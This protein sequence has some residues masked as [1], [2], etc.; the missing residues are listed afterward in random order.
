VRGDGGRR[1]AGHVLPFDVPAPSADGADSLFDAHVVV[2]DE[3]SHDAALE[4]A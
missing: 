1:P 4:E 2:V 3:Q